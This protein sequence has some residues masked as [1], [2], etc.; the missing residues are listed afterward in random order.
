VTEGYP[1][2]DPNEFDFLLSAFL[3]AARSVDWRL[4]HE[5][6]VLYP[7]WRPNWDASLTP[8]QKSLMR[9]LVNDRNVEVHESGSKRREDLVP[10]GVQMDGSEVVAFVR[11][12][13]ARPGAI[14]A[15]EYYFPIDGV[16]RRATEAC[17]EYIGLLRAMV[18]KF[19]TDH[20]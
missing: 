19:Q 7:G 14:A 2:G 9:H 20:C 3:S 5:Q 17:T 1:L 10:L 15:S 16:E 11:L 12:P 4:A 8:E 13:E 18:A 6:Q